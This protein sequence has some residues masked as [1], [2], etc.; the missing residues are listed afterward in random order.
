MDIGRSAYTY[1]NKENIK[2]VHRPQAVKNTRVRGSKFKNWYVFRIKFR[3]ENWN[4]SSIITKYS[5]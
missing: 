1:V 5:I 4:N 3:I 2:K